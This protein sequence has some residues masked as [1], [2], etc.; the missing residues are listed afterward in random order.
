M[1]EDRQFFR[2]LAKKW[3]F[4][5]T[6][7]MKIEEWRG[8]TGEIVDD[9]H[10]FQTNTSSRMQRRIANSIKSINVAREKLTKDLESRAKVLRRAKKDG[11][12]TVI[13]HVDAHSFNLAHL[14][15][16]LR[17]QR[18]VQEAGHRYVILYWTP[19]VDNEGG[20]SGANKG[21]YRSLQQ[22]LPHEGRNVLFEVSPED[23]RDFE[24]VAG[25]HNEV[26]DSAFDCF[27]S[28]SMF[29]EP[30][31]VL[32]DGVEETGYT[33]WRR[34]CADRIAATWLSSETRKRS[35]DKSGGGGGSGDNEEHSQ[36]QHYWLLDISVE[37]VGSLPRMLARWHERKS[38]AN[39]KWND[40]HY[41]GSCAPAGSGSRECHSELQRL[42][43]DLLLH[44]YRPLPLSHDRNDSSTNPA[45]LCGRSVHT[46]G[47]EHPPASHPTFGQRAGLDCSVSL[48]LI[49]DQKR[50]L[51]HATG[52]LLDIA[53]REGILGADFS[54]ATGGEG[55]LLYTTVDE[56]EH[57][58]LDFGHRDSEDRGAMRELPTEISHSLYPPLALLGRLYRE[59]K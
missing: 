32:E 19:T 26:T 48:S 49:E 52:N 54:P 35:N 3:D 22:A 12:F 2:D 21:H 5:I 58:V 56:F 6:T 33:F 59:V 8:W 24:S 55:E 27:Q 51:E 17:A 23:L 18:Q 43:L 37:W 42:S 44:M 36:T 20:D 47:P 4:D 28:F 15:K 38:R 13:H 1:L 41:L 16:L 7:Q 14:K 39:K 9:F 11:R 53:T 10:E 50:G 25:Y 30:A 45:P 57:A 29:R 34:R 40:T 46:H 31:V